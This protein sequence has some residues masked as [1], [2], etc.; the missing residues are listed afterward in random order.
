MNSKVDEI[1]HNAIK[2]CINACEYIMRL[3]WDKL[4]RECM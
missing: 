3:L 1:L 2:V 4:T